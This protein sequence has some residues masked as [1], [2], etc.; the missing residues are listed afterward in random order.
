M[1][2][3]KSMTDEIARLRALL[4]AKESEIAALRSA[5]HTR[6]EIAG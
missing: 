3:R 1:R 2:A 4:E 5:L 6:E